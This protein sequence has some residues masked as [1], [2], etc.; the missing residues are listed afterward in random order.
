MTEAI[1]AEGLC[2]RFGEVTA[3]DGVDLR[4]RPGQVLGLLGPNGSGK[5]TAVRILSTLTKP[6]AG[7][8]R[9]Y[10][11]DVV[12]DAARVRQLIA[13]TGQYAAV[14]ENLTGTENLVLMGR[15]LELNRSQARLR[16]A[17][18][19][20][21][22]GLT[23]AGRRTARTYSGGMRRRLDL[24]ASLVGR[25][26]VLFLDE[27]TTGL[28][29]KSRFELWRAVRRLAA[30]GTSVLLTTQ[31]LEEADQ[32]ADDLLVINKGRVAASG[33][34]EALKAQTGGRTLVIRPSDPDKLGTALTAAQAVAARATEEDSTVVVGSADAALLS[35]VLGSLSAAGVE[36]DEA[37]LRK[38]S[39]DEAFLAILGETAM[40]EQ[41]ETAG[42]D[43]RTPVAANTSKEHAA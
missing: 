43:Q 24:A 3:L 5:T 37:G 28:D 13:L 25:P 6:D 36:V 14:D 15:L 20:E 12:R 32:L 8:A 2:K 30:E 16:A 17:E 10:G 4:I 41:D 31:Y 19:L 11:Y 29:P 26:R 27:P 35:A 21:T 38:P 9:I 22:F 1:L 7:Q 42:T 39:L 33:T 23:E 34:A 40:P 18:L